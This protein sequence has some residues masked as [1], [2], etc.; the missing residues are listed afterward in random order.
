VKIKEKSKTLDSIVHSLELREQRGLVNWIEVDTDAKS[1]IVK[2]L[3]E[4]K[5]MP[6]A[7]EETLI[8]E[9]YSK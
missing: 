5:D 3:P 1:A 7:V 2:A 9:F 8:V 4:R 6:M